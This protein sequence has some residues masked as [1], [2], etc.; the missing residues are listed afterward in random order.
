M[1]D[2]TGDS[3]SVLVLVVEVSVVRV[4]S[5][6]SVGLRFEEEVGVDAAW[7]G[8]CGWLRGMFSGALGGFSG[9]LGGL[10]LHS[11]G[12][13]SNFFL[14]HC[15]TATTITPMVVIRA[16]VKKPSNIKYNWCQHKV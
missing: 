4:V 15:L 16:H 5:S 14:I 8:V 7:G 10:F 2:E 6:E 11:H 9:A 13:R 1:R 12:Q 3:I